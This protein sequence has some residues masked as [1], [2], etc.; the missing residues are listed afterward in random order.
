MLFCHVSLLKWL[1]TAYKV[2]GNLESNT[3]LRILLTIPV[4]IALIE[5]SKL[6][7]KKTKV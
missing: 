7:I 6:E 2:Y 4:M 1:D 3:P 5:F